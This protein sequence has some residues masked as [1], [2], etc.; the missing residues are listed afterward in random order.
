MVSRLWNLVAKFW[1]LIQNDEDVFLFRS[2]KFNETSP[3]RKTL[4]YFEVHHIVVSSQR[5]SLSCLCRSRRCLPDVRAGQEGRIYWSENRK[6]RGPSRKVG[7]DRTPPD[8]ETING[9]TRRTKHH[10]ATE[11]TSP[12]TVLSH[13]TCSTL[14]LVLR[15][16]HSKQVSTSVDW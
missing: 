14:P 12:S 9:S 16:R 2:D 15:E 10:R 3:Y 1:F 13:N 11:Q 4:H 6:T 5:V 8:T 7:P